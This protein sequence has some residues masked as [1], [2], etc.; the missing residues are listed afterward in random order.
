MLESYGVKESNW[1]NIVYWNLG[2]VGENNWACNGL[3]IIE[4]MFLKTYVCWSFQANNPFVFS[5][6]RKASTYYMSGGFMISSN[7]NKFWL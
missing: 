3:Q 4:D 6:V 7:N 2:V 1:A 5:F